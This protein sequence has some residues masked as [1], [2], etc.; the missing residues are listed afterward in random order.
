MSE[1]LKALNGEI[2]D[3]ER[4]LAG[5]PVYVK[6]RRAQELRDAYL[7]TDVVTDV[8]QPAAVQHDP[9]RAARPLSSGNSVI[10]LDAVKA[11]LRGRAHPMPTREIISKLGSAGIEIGGSVPQNN[12]SSLLSKS[13]DIVSHGRSGWTLGADTEKADD[14]GPE[15]AASSASVSTSAPVEPGEEVAHEE[16]GDIFR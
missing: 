12:L 13:P 7:I 11:Y 9:S 6:L 1:F 14:A 8:A 16:V 10:V 2:V 3:L 5:S 15:Q 4:Q